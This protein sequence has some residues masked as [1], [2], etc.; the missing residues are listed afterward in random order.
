MKESNDLVLKYSKGILGSLDCTHVSSDFEHSLA[1]MATKYLK[2]D[3]I[4]KST[5]I[6]C[7]RAQQLYFKVLLTFSVLRLIICCHRNLFIIDDIT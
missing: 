1:K 7:R 6:F 5:S 2:R 3:D 4:P